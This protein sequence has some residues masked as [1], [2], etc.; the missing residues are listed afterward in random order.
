MIRQRVYYILTA[1]S[2]NNPGSVQKK[3]SE[4][5]AALQAQGVDAIGLFFS[6]EV[7]EEQST[8][9]AIR[10]IPVIFNPQGLF[11]M[12]RERRAFEKA[13]ENYGKENIE[14]DAKIY[15]R[16]VYASRYLLRFFKAFQ[17][18]IVVNHVT[19]EIPE[20]NLYKPNRDSGFVS[21]ILGLLENKWIPIYQEVVYGSRIRKYAKCAI[22]NSADIGSYENKL[23]VGTYR[24]HCIPDGVVANAFPRHRAPVFDGTVNMV[25]LKG[26]TTDAV[27][28]GIDRLVQSLKASALKEKFNLTIIGPNQQEDVKMVEQLGMQEYIHFK[29]FMSKEELDVELNTYHLGVSTLALHRKGIRSTSTIKSREYCARG[30]PFIYGHHDPDLSESIIAG[31]YCLELPADESLI[32][33]EA[34]YDFVCAIYAQGSSMDGL[35]EFAKAQLDQSVKMR[36][37]KAVLFDE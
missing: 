11:R 5:I 9:Q 15:F 32:D 8:D 12:L 4:Q 24:Y 21:R 19:S 26:A 37:L 35:C 22:V 13:I 14:I 7:K 2:P 17:G 27:Y 10:F 16:Y 31:K 23:S 30:I 6:T 33:F 34:V 18:R 28:N 36:Q 20:I 3:V 29:G 1:A 25:F